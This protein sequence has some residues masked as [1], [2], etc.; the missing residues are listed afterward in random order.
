MVGVGGELLA[1]DQIDDRLLALAAEEGGEDSKN[2]QRVGEQDFG[3]RQHP[4]DNLGL[5]RV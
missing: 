1:Q 4:A 3:S 2:E 5:V